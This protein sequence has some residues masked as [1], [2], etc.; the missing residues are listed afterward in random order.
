MSSFIL[1]MSK[2]FRYQT[3]NTC[4]YS[5][6]I[7]S[8]MSIL[9]S[10]KLWCFGPFLMAVSGGRRLAIA[11]WASKVQMCVYMCGLLLLTMECECQGLCFLLAPLPYRPAKNCITAN[12]EKKV[13]LSQ[14]WQGN[15]LAFQIWSSSPEC[16]VPQHRQLVL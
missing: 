15:Q 8:L 11:R 12:L 13:K 6:P 10:Q 5:R 16:P 4:Q 2:P 9:L 1:N 3:S 7:Q 14:Y